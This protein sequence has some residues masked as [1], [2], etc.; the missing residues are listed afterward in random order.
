MSYCK[1][2]T[3]VLLSFGVQTYAVI[4]KVVETKLFQCGSP[5]GDIVLL[6][7]CFQVSCWWGWECASEIDYLGLSDASRL[8]YK[9]AINLHHK[10]YQNLIKQ[11][12]APWKMN[13]LIT[14]KI[15][16]LSWCECNICCLVLCDQ[17]I[18]RSIVCWKLFLQF[19][20]RRR[21]LP[22]C[23]LFQLLAFCILVMQ[24][25]EISANLSFAIQ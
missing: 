11:R 18:L 4:K 16:F 5:L 7:F 19:Y 15:L 23:L 2:L 24:W 12:E 13:L 10:V 6:C 17:W 1:L 25:N 3:T 8:Y 14:K 21:S 9:H 22:L 20:N